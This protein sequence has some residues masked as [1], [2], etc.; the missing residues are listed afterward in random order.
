MLNIQN[1]LALAGEEVALGNFESA[2]EYVDE[3]LEVHPS[4]KEALWQRFYIP[5]QYYVQIIC[6]DFK[7]GKEIASSESYEVDY[8]LTPHSKKINDLKAESLFYIKTYF[9]ISTEKER[10]ELF[11]KL[12]KGKLLHLVKN[13]LDYLLELDA[14]ALNSNSKI[15]ALIL[16]YCNKIYLENLKHRREN[17]PGIINLKNFAEEN[18]KRTDPP[19]FLEMNE[20]FNDTKIWM[21]KILA[22][23]DED[24]RKKKKVEESRE[25]KFKLNPV[26]WFSFLIILMI[27]M[28]FILYKILLNYT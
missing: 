24:R 1:K 11:N 9:Q 22:E 14:L 5:Y 6:N 3:V 28:F 26:Y 25:K 21:E 19:A 4:N 15:S 7:I 27:I 17:P 2:I 20:N 8:D 16:E 12:E 10:T 23:D 18:L 13:N